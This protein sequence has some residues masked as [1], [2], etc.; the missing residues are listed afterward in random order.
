MPKVDVRCLHC[1]GQAPDPIGG[2]RPRD[3]AGLLLDRTAKVP[4]AD[5][6]ECLVIGSERAAEEGP[7]DPIDREREVAVA[8]RG[9]DLNVL[10]QYAGWMGVA[11]PMP[12]RFVVDH[13]VSL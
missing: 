5:A 7:V 10:D 12:G 8:G 2:K 9:L 1:S 4:I 11:R 6:G 3:G 13:C